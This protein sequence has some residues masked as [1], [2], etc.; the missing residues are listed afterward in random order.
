MKNFKIPILVL[1]LFI[2]F[3]CKQSTGNLSVDKKDKVEDKKNHDSL[4]LVKDTTLFINSTEGEDVKLLFDVS[5]K[6]SVIQSN[7]YSEMGRSTYE[8]VF[9]KILKKASCITYRYEEPISINSDPRISTEKKED[10]ASSV[11][12][13]KRLTDIFRSY[14]KVLNPAFASK[15]KAELNSKWYGKYT[16]T[17]NAD[18]EDWRNI[19]EIELNISSKSVTYLAKGFQ[20]YQFFNLSADEKNGYLELHYLNSLDNTESWALNKTKNFGIL[21]L[22]GNE[23]KWSSPYLNIYF[24]DGKSSNYTIVKN[25]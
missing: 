9:N 24:N 6:D 15:S 8:F 21:V 2:I 11:E 5:N 14:Q 1:L 7:M 10:L 16:L 23:Y 12:A 25:K 3:Q 19:H 17:L 4:I 20:L 13:R 22:N 18:D